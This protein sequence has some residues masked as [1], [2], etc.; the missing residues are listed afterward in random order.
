MTDPRQMR[1]QAAG[2]FAGLLM[3]AA[4][5]A[6]SEAGPG[7]SLVQGNLVQVMLGLAAVLALIAVLAWASRR[8]LRLPGGGAGRMQV[9]AA[10]SLG[11]RERVVLVEVGGRQVLLAVAPGHIAS[12]QTLEER[13]DFGLAGGEDATT[14]Q[15][16][17]F[18]AVLARVTG[19]IAGSPR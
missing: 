1:A 2:G 15:P 11:P 8:F 14:A 6:A 17:G 7:V 5:A 18:P 13:I 3:A 19:G 12:L 4:P 10:L 16:A 9:V